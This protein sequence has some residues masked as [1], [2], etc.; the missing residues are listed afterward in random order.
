MNVNQIIPWKINRFIVATALI[1]LGAA[2]RIWPLHSLGSIIAWLT[3]YPAVTVAAVYGGFSAGLL[4][5]VL[6]CLTAIFLGPL[7]VDKPFIDEPADWLGLAIYFLNCMLI[8]IVAEAM[9]RAND[10]AK[11]AQEQAEA[12]NK[13]KSVFLAN[14]S[15]ELRTPL[16]AILGFSSIMRS[17]AGISGKQRKNIDIINRSG[18]HLLNL[19]NDVL[20]M[21]K[22]E[23]GRVSVEIGA[24]D[25]GDMVRGITD[26]MRIRAE[27]KGLSLSVDQSSKFPRFVRSDTAKLRQIL[28]NLVSNAIKYTRRGGVIL[29]LN[30]QPIDAQYPL[31]LIFEV[32]DSGVGVAASD[33]TR[34]FDPFVQA[35]KQTIH[36]G[37]GLGLAIT[38]NFVKLMDGR[39]T[40]ESVLGKGSTFRV[41]IPV[42]RAEAGEVSASGA[43]RRLVASLASGLPEYRILIVEDQMENWLL[44]QQLLENAG[45]RVKVAQNG[46]E[47]VEAFSSW[48][49]HYIWMDVRMPV[50]DGLEAARRIRAL[51]GGRDVK[52]VALTA[53][54]FKE[55][56]DNIIA[57]GMDDFIR[58]PYRPEEIFDCLTHHLGVC[59]VYEESTAESTANPNGALRPE[60]MAALPQDMRRELGEALV[61]LDTARL[62]EL[63]GRVSG[64]DPALGDALAQHADR[65]DYTTLHQAIKA[66]ADYSAERA[67]V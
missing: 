48:K 23:S 17:D 18:E 60:A 41:E 36:E 57:A 22:I 27:E 32:Q 66:G 37:T 55:E 19:I 2:L 49:P 5:T 25:L 24:C 33:L 12:S 51:D 53:S 26:L 34:I 21:A 42:E 64:L 29:R 43:N 56:R 61:S 3:F 47:G 4:A 63:I 15:H 52:I 50:M 38:R 13:A 62:T 65:L 59:F 1:A 45:F 67:V 11:K 14:M 28:I 39:L 58:K 8:S 40:V 46:A 30:A 20:D 9:Q 31:L 44:L 54:V 16:N 6:S 7:L 35:G 10:R